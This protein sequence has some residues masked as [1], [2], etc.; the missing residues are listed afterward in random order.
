MNGD[1]ASSE[2]ILKAY[3]WIKDKKALSYK[4]DVKAVFT[5]RCRDSREIWMRMWMKGEKNR[6]IIQA[7][8]PRNMEY[9]RLGNLMPYDIISQ[10]VLTFVARQYGEAWTHP[11]VAIYEPSDSGEPSEIKQVSYF[12]P[13][14]EDPA[15]IGICV[16]LKNG[17][18]DYIFSASK[19]T[20]MT[21]KGM[22]V[23]GR[24]G[25]VTRWK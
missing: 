11:F 21:Y 6:H 20:Q 24:Y 18:K 19:K 5:T 7:L 3:S 22:C 23:E 10:P 16:E 4:G 8:S 17:R 2:N 13:K 15:A 14:S 9:E 25:V 12:S 1:F